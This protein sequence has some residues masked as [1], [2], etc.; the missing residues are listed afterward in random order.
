MGFSNFMEV[1]PIP[2]LQGGG[3]SWSEVEGSEGDGIYVLY[4]TFPFNLA[5][6][7]LNSVCP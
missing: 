6:T 7:R 3:L 2:P 4:N 5:P 1:F